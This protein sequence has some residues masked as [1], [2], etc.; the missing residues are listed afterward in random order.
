MVKKNK[1]QYGKND[2]YV[3]WIIRSQV[4]KVVM[5]RLWKRFRD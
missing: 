1:L 5:V 4:P 3:Q 2:L